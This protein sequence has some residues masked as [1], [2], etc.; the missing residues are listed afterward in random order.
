[1]RITIKLNTENDAFQPDW[2]DEVRRILHELGSTIDEHSGV[3]FRVLDIN[4]N[5]CGQVTFS[6]RVS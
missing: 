1:M 4:G 3:A 2:Q 6:P 5:D